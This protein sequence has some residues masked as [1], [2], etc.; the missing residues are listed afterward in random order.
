M[1]AAESGGDQQ[2]GNGLSTEVMMPIT[3]RGTK[4]FGHWWP[5]EVVRQDRL[6]SFKNVRLIGD[7]SSPQ[8]FT[9]LLN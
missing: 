3:G 5:D 6:G 8:L 9:P 2:S 1:L 7:A 4:D